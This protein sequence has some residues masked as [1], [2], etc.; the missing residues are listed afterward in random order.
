M[1]QGGWARGREQC[2]KGSE[3]K[4]RRILFWRPP[5]KLALCWSGAGGGQAGEPGHPPLAI[6]AL[7]SSP[8]S[9]KEVCLSRE[10]QA[11]E[12]VDK[13]ILLF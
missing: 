7:K 10:T 6:L 5:N 12:D 11:G 9:Q 4:V 8:T 13:E 3:Q 1:G 2:K